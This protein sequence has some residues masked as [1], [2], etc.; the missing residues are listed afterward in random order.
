MAI[1]HRAVLRAATVG[2]AIPAAL[3]YRY[4]KVAEGES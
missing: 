2:I 1:L 4:L 3:T